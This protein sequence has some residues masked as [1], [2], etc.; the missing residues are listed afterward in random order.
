ML[1]RLDWT[2]SPSR[3]MDGVSGVASKG[4]RRY[5]PIKAGS[6]RACTTKRHTPRSAILAHPARREA[7]SSIFDF[8]GKDARD[9]IAPWQCRRREFL[10]DLQ[11]AGPE[12][13][14][15]AISGN[16]PIEL[17]PVVAILGSVPN[18]TFPA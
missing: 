13:Q 2:T 4:W 18:W 15:K 11:C 16:L 14:T 12:A 5:G 6:R 7:Q 9:I 17:L 3:A 10:E 1:A 8:P